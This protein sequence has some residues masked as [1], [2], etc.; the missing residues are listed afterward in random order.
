MRLWSYDSRTL[1]LGIRLLA[2]YDYSR[3]RPLAYSN[4]YQGRQTYRS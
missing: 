2:N 3:M 4:L 1:V